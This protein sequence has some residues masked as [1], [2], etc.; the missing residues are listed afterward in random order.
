M[1]ESSTSSS[2]LVA[3]AAA[4]AV[5]ARAL[6]LDSDLVCAVVGNLILISVCG[7]EHVM[8]ERACALLRRA[9]P[10]RLRRRVWQSQSGHL[11]GSRRVARAEQRLKTTTTTTTTMRYI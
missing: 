3:V 5:A 11:G 4:A 1:S 9:V 8:L 6:A 10:L 7:A 2:L